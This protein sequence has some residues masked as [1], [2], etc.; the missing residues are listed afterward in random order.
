MFFFLYLSVKKYIK[1][2]IT[3]ALSSADIVS[4]LI[5]LVAFMNYQILRL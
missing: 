5:D 4:F 1:N 2:G 3:Y